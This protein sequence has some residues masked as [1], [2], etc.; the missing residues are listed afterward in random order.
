M[1]PTKQHFASSV[2]GKLPE[3]ASA[4]AFILNKEADPEEVAGHVNKALSD[5]SAHPVN[6]LTATKKVTPS[7]GLDPKNDEDYT[8]KYTYRGEGLFGLEE[9]QGQKPA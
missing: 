2:E 7:A 8:D 6:W 1:S 4:T 9:G 5:R 3:K